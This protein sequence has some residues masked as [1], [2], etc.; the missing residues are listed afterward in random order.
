MANDDLL[1]EHLLHCLNKVCKSSDDHVVTNTS[2]EV[3]ED[4][5]LFLQILIS[6]VVV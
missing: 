4:G 1:D 5:T 6:R 3:S 2:G